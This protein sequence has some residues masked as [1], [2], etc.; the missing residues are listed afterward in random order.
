MGDV[1][2]DAQGELVQWE[3]LRY[4]NEQPSK[5]FAIDRETL[6]GHPERG[7]WKVGV[8]TEQVAQIAEDTA[9]KLGYW[10]RP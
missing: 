3:E 6:G 8:G 1:T 7:D 5:P 10:E 9:L 2:S 4:L